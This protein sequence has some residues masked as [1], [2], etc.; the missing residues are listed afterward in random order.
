MGTRDR[1]FQSPPAMPWRRSLPGAF[2]ACRAAR[3]L[4]VGLAVA[5]VLC[6]CLSDPPADPEVQPLEIVAGNPD[7]KYGPCLLN[8]EEVGAGTHD[9]TQLSMAGKA[10]VRILDPSGVAIFERTIEEHP[11]EGGGQEVLE[12][13][14]GSVRLGEGTHRVEC[15]LSDGTHTSE[16][17]VVP[18]RPGYEEE[19]VG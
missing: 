18:A 12:E 15:I 19:G 2:R 8:V 16:L 10:T 1:L 17:Q 4:S 9:V 6:G 7:P 13:D 3:R 14:Q 5:T 11:V